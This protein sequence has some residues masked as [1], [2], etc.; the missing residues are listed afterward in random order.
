MQRVIRQP[1]LI[2]ARGLDPVGTGRQVELVV[3]GLA[4]LGVDVHLAL[5]SGGGSLGR[6]LA[7]AGVPVHDVGRR[8]APDAAAVTRLAGLARRLAPA[9]VIAFGGR[10]AAAL[11]AARPL[12][13]RTVAVA[14]LAT[15]L[16]GR[17]VGWAVRGCDRVVATSE[18][19]A[20]SCRRAGVAADRILVVPPGIE[21]DPGSGLSRRELGDRLGLD[22]AKHWTLCVAP[23]ETASRLERLLWGIDQLGVVRRD[24]E[25]V[26]VGEGPRLGMLE[27]RA[28]IQ[29]LSERLVVLPHCD[30]IGDLLAHVR[31]VWQSGCVALGGALLDGMARGVPAVAVDGD[32]ARQIVADGETGRIV[33]P[34]PESDLA[35]RAFG[36]V[37][38]D[39]LAARY[40]A[41]AAT[42]ARDSFPPGPL[43]EAFE[44]LLQTAAD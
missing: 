26:L 24:V 28:Q 6:R 12:V 44:R 15:P 40:A 21:A 27:R 23:L 36:I 29:R 17:L 7:A 14:C 4:A 37:E 1:V 38:D 9:A 39:A 34:E 5:A 13:P 25:H 42:R 30:V 32:A 10:Q 35:R 8:P 20:S 22:V 31:L 19:I 33:K 43:V 2:V 16:R 41:A 11:A 18:G 3:R